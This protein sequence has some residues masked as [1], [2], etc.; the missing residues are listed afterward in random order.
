[1]VVAG[2]GELSP[3]GIH[4]AATLSGTAP[5]GRIRAPVSSL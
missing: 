5:N 4:H 1:L 3:V 2:Y